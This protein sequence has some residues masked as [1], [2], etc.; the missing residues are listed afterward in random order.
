MTINTTRYNID[1]C[2]MLVEFNTSVWTARKLDRS[3]TDELVHNKKAGS[4]DAARVN[5]HLL[6]GRKELEVIIQHVGNVRNRFVYPQTLPWSDSGLRLLPT[7]NFMKFNTRMQE[8]EEIFW[9][10]VNE[11]ID[12]YPSLITAQ[13]MALGEMFDR[14]DFPSADEIKTKFNFS[15]NYL[16][17]PDAGDFRINVGNEAMRELEQ[18][19]DKYVEERVGAA[20]ADV[21]A[22]LKE[23]L[24][25]MSNRL[26]VD[27]VNGES[28]TRRFHDTM[29]EAGYELCDLVKGLNVT[30]DQDV[31]NVRRGLEHA[32][33]G[34]T[35]EDLRRNTQVRRDVKAEVDSILKK[36]SW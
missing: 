6:A 36:M 35:N 28:K 10:L 2:S 18:K 32:L 19:A 17:V 12:V 22:R 7:I 13:A 21:R 20:M 5:K 33:S 15:Y 29:L 34:V 1:T 24:Q 9:K 27:I 25:R 16:P 11:F 4:K 30:N 14:N 26:T 8:E 3:T 23:H 31:E